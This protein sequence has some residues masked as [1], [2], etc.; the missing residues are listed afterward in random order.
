VSL[1]I[2]GFLLQF[3]LNKKLPLPAMFLPKASS[4]YKNSKKALSF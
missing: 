1:I 4:L 3:C 2:T